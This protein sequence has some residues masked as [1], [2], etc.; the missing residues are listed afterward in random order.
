[1]KTQ[2]AQIQQLIKEL[3]LLHQESSK[4]FFES[5]SC[6]SVNFKKKQVRDIIN[7]TTGTIETSFLKLIDEYHE[8]LGD[9]IVDMEQEYD[10]SCFD[11]RSRIKQKESI[12]NK[13]IYYR[14]GKDEQGKSA[15]LKCLNDM[16]GCRII[17]NEF[18]HEGTDCYSIL[19]D[20]GIDYKIDGRNASKGND[21]RAS[22][23]YFYGQNIYFPWELQIWLPKDSQKNEQ[24][25]KEHKSK[26]AYISWPDDYNQPI[27]YEKRGED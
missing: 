20:I 11:F 25:H 7:D 15:L 21:Y 8:N 26:R 17:V 22:H 5:T 1:M 6:A 27:E 18:D 9:L 10:Y 23:I 12:L 16:L 4:S 2:N 24:S 19:N 3:C 14:Y 13:L